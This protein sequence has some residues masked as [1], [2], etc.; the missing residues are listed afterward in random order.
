M[1]LIACLSFV[2]K[3]LFRQIIAELF[4]CNLNL[5]IKVKQYFHK[6]V[7]IEYINVAIWSYCYLDRKKYTI[8]SHPLYDYIFSVV[9]NKS[10][11]NYI[12]K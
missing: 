9:E 1:F 12:I 6:V 4:D 5:N 10:I 7:F 8:S 11:N 3:D 2:S